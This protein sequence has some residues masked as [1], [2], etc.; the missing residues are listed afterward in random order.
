M[1]HFA[2]IGLTLL[3]VLVTGCANPPEPPAALSG[4]VPKPDHIYVAYYAV[5]PDEV[6]IDKGVSI[7]VGRAVGDPSLPQRD[8]L[9]ARRARADL[10]IAVVEQLNRLGLPAEVATNNAANGDGLLLQGQIAGPDPAKRSRLA[11]VGLNGG[12]GP[13]HAETQL[14][15]VAGGAQPRLLATFGSPGGEGP[16]TGADHTLSTTAAEAIAA[17][18]TR[19]AKE[20]GWLTRTAAK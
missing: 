12:K 8:L 11:L 18:I 3:T 19:F 15:Q 1:R 4:P 17:H 6:R 9:A 2:G 5:A 7:R 10:A 14:F 13:I 20:Q 16:I